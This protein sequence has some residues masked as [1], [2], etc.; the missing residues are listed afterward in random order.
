[1]AD[2]K[3]TGL[4]G[5]THS[6]W[7]AASGFNQQEDPFRSTEAN[8]DKNW[9]MVPKEG[10][11]TLVKKR[12][13]HVSQ[14]SSNSEKSSNVTRQSSVTSKTGYR[15]SMDVVQAAGTPPYQNVKM[16]NSDISSQSGPSSPDLLLDYS[17][18]HLDSQDAG[19]PSIDIQRPAS[20][21]IRMSLFHAEKSHLFPTTQGVAMSHVPVHID[22]KN[23][24]DGHPALDEIDEGRIHNLRTKALKLRS[25]IRSGRRELLS[26]QRAKSLADEAFMKYIR[27]Y[28][29]APQAILSNSLDSPA[30]TSGNPVLEAHYTAMQA[31]RNDYGPVED[32]YNLMEEE[33][34][35]ID[36][37]L[38][39]LE[40]RS[41]KTG[42]KRNSDYVPTQ[43]SKRP[44]S[45]ES[46]FGLSDTLEKTHH[47]KADLLSRLGDLD[48]AREQLQNLQ[49]EREQ[50]LAVQESRSSL[51]LDISEYERCFLADFSAAEAAIRG[52]IGELEEDIEQI[53]SKC[54]E[55]GVDI[56]ESNSGSYEGSIKNTSEETVGE[57]EESGTSWNDLALQQLK[58]YNPTTPWSELG[59]VFR[60]AKTSD[61]SI[62]IKVHNVLNTQYKPA[63]TQVLDKRQ[64]LV[65]SRPESFYSMFPLLLPN[66]DKGKADLDV[67]IAEFEEKD[68]NDRINRWML[69]KLRTSYYEVDLLLRVFF[70]FAKIVDFRHW[71][72]GTTEWELW[73]LLHWKW[74][75][76]N[77]P[78]HFF[79]TTQTPSSVIRSPV[80]VTK[81]TP[82]HTNSS[83]GPAGLHPISE[84]GPKVRSASA[85]IDRNILSKGI[86]ILRGRRSRGP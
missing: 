40:A 42:A 46:F 7:K 37:E 52:E 32:E 80:S 8:F 9:N 82:A 85:S 65:Y 62:D 18:N 16:K 20:P 5:F 78:A 45:P 49:H 67:L 15:T 83:R 79:E 23:D 2:H 31:A 72:T 81:S 50:L 71:P 36:Y 77:K 41:T 6:R 27:E 35:E 3:P 11:Y 57:T 4:G 1:M 38:A 70:E 69:H 68:K 26:K 25:R 53:K 44:P 10:R 34:D 39:I 51:G 47:L 29:P 21:R 22:E 56:S 28:R 24:S 19:T 84:L 43:T 58:D 61:R 74:D 13:Q 66:S 60:T 14:G 76:A 73:V 17:T 55:A 54:L 59:L 33:L 86:E 64:R 12:K 63:N 75:K 48:L 30:L